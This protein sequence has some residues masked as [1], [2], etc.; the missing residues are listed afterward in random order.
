MPNCIPAK[1][2]QYCLG[3]THIEVVVSIG[4]IRSVVTKNRIHNLISLVWQYSPRKGVETKSTQIEIVK[5]S[6]NENECACIHCKTYG[7]GNGRA[8]RYV[9]HAT[10]K[11]GTQAHSG[12]VQGSQ[13]RGRVVEGPGEVVSE[14]GGGGVPHR[15][16]L[17][18]EVIFGGKIWGRGTHTHTQS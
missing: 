5:S 8:L 3:Q 16:A 13:H 18:D 1:H 14:H 11:G 17:Q 10:T 4:Q 2:S 7:N 15:G 12:R 6:N 9:H